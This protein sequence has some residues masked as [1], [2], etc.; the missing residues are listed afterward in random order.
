M[1]PRYTELVCLDKKTLAV[2]WCWHSEDEGWNFY[3]ATSQWN[4]KFVFYHDCNR[5]T[6]VTVLDR[7]GREIISRKVSDGKVLDSGNLFV[8]NDRL[9]MRTTESPYTVYDLNKMLDSE[10]SNEDCI[11]FQEKDKWKAGLFTKIVSDGI[12][13]YL[14]SC[15]IG[16]SFSECIVSYNMK[17]N[18]EI[19]RTEL[20]G[21]Y[22]EVHGIIT[23][24]K[25]KLYVPADYGSVYCLDAV[26]GK[27][28]WHTD[29]R[30]KNDELYDVN[31]MENSCVVS[32]RWL[33]I[34]CNSNQQLLVLD[35]N[36]GEIMARIKGILTPTTIQCFSEG[37][38]LYLAA[39]HGLYRFNFWEK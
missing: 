12:H 13:A 29:I 8:K 20:D 34:P 15:C 28:L 5:T 32:D 26:T 3:S 9:Y 4:D 18:K 23:L 33:C 25:E 16:E 37:D 10:T 11:L 35:I 21:I 38:Y 2:L 24:H 19:W 39:S 30:K 27:Q 1:F 6:I 17:D 14:P 31:L 7:Q 22:D 36:N